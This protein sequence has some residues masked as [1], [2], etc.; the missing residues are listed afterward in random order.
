M[1]LSRFPEGTVST[2]VSGDRCPG[3]AAATG[4]S[5][6][7]TDVASAVPELVLSADDRSAIEALHE[8]WLDAELRAD[9]SAVL[10]LCTAAPIWLPPNDAPLCGRLAIRQWLNAQPPAHVQRVEIV[11]LEISGVG[12]FACKLARF[13]TILSGEDDAAV[14]VVT[15][16]HGWLLQRDDEGAWRVA[17]VAW[18]IDGT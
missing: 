1:P 16:S 2:G 8:T 6:P 11:G 4:K 13:R 15:G 9:S 18:T 17:V 10:E 14:E 3:A 5:N 12:P 7:R